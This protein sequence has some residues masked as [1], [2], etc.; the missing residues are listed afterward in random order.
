MPFHP[1]NKNS[2]IYVAN[3]SLKISTKKKVWAMQKYERNK[4]VMPKKHEPKK[5]RNKRC[6]AKE[7]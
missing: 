3:L 6:H 4:N 2:I 7:A 5:E 1:P